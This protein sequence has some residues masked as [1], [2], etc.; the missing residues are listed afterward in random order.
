MTVLMLSDLWVPFPGGCERLAFGLARYLLRD[1]LDVHVLTGY[2]NAQRF[3]G[4]PV[5][6]CEIGIGPTHDDGW[7]QIAAQIAAWEPDVI[8]THHLY[9]YEFAGEL[10]ASG[11][12]V[13]QVVL[14]NARL[15]WVA[16][17]VHIT[18]HVRS[19]AS[20][21]WAE[22]MTIRPPAFDDVAASGHGGAIGFI[23]PIPHKG[24]DM[25]YAIAEQMPDRQFVILRGEWIDLEV[26]RP[27]ANVE[28]MDPVDD[29]RDFYARC[30]LMLM[31]SR[32]ED[33]GTV[34]Q[35]ATVNGL[36]CISSNVGGL[37]ETNG[38][39]ILLDPYDLGAWLTSI[40]ALDDPEVYGQIVARQEA[41]HARLGTDAALAEFARR[42]R[43]LA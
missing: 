27:M 40:R 35:E 39:G 30:R 11:I 15:G 14:N 16:F 26:I 4:P 2:E 17:A 6:G 3:D 43:A 5:Y 31:P 13:V 23:K 21:W 19:L 10:E 25:V 12:P 29:I 20:G 28:F 41:Y 33:A 22:D 8:L 7:A 38:G 18:E 24:V 9:A 42:I 32:S 34:A 36:P 1:G 37:P